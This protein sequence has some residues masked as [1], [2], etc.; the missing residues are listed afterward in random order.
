MLV[1]VAPIVLLKNKNK[2]YS[3]QYKVAQLV[4]KGTNLFAFGLIKSKIRKVH[5]KEY[6]ILVLIFD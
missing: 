3:K 1:I 2:V 6:N 4:L 5:E